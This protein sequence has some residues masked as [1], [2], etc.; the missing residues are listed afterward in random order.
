MRWVKK[1][2]V[3]SSAIPSWWSTQPSRVTLML[4]VKS[5]MA[6][7]LLRVG[8]TAGL[9]LVDEHLA[10]PNDCVHL[11]AGSS[12]RDISKNRNAGPSSATLCSPAAIART[13]QS[14]DYSGPHFDIIVEEVLSNMTVSLVAKAGNATWEKHSLQALLP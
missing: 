11:R 10:A 5:P 1:A 3:S 6:A 2:C 9:S 7:S 4:K 12:E 8:R 14:A 13:A